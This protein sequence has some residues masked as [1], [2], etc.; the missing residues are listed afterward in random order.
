MCIQLKLNY[1][2]VWLVAAVSNVS[3]ATFTMMYAL[4]LRHVCKR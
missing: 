1:A 3:T 2:V 4:F